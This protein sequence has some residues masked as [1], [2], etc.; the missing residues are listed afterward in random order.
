M[1]HLGNIE[2]WEEASSRGL[3]LEDDTH[4]K[5]AKETVVYQVSI[6]PLVPICWL[7]SYKQ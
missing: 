3:Y 1:H 6:F 7:G 2:D 4:K 5:I